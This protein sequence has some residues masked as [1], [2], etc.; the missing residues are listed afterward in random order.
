MAK[1]FL[2][3]LVFSLL[4]AGCVSSYDSGTPEGVK[5]YTTIYSSIEKSNREANAHC[6]RYQ[7]KAV[8]VRSEWWPT[9]YDLYKCE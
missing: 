1:R 9:K 8:F 3:I 7:K 6:S 2:M 4:V 5:I